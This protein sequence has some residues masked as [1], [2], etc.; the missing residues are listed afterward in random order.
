M[1]KPKVCKHCNGTGRNPMKKQVTWLE[2]RTS[3]L[4]W[5]STN[6]ANNTCTKC[7]GTGKRG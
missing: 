2:A 7:R 4:G 5:A 6:N 3:G 1:A